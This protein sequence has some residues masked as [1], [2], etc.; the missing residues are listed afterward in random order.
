MKKKVLSMFLASVM[1]LSIV[2]CGS[3][4]GGSETQ[5][6]TDTAKQETATESETTAEPETAS[7]L[8][9]HKCC[10]NSHSHRQCRRAPFFPQPLW[11]ASFVDF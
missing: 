8:V 2:A 1:A 6:G 9:D 4:N 3:S 5:T 10:T 7:E 11:H